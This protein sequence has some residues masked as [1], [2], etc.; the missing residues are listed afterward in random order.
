V[1]IID[2]IRVGVEY[3][4]MTMRMAVGFGSFPTFVIMIVM[5]IVDV[6]VLVEFL[7]V[8]VHQNHLVMLWPQRG[9]QG[10]KYQDTLA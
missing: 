4:P 5:K 10:R 3:P 1:V 8:G 6:F 9:S 2:D 7:R